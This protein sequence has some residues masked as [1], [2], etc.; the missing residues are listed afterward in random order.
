MEIY[1]KTLTG[2]T[3]TIWNLKSSDTIAFLKQRLSDRGDGIPPDQQRLI[4]VREGKA[5]QLDDGKTLLDY[6]IE[7]YCTLHLVL[8]LRGQSYGTGDINLFGLLLPML[9]NE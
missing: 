5:L 2:K 6:N 3:L 7:Q 4:F 8:R 9:Q 1:I